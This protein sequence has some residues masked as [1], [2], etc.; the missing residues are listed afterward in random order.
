MGIESIRKNNAEYLQQA[1]I[2]CLSK[3]QSNHHRQLLWLSGE[4]T[5][6]YQQLKSLRLLLT[7]KNCAGVHSKA[8]LNEYFNIEKNQ[9]L[10]GTQIVN[11][12]CYKYLGQEFKT[13]I[14]DAYS[15]LNPDHLAQISPTLMGG[16]VL[17][18][19]TP[20][21]D[22]W[23]NWKEAELNNLFTQPFTRQH[24][25][26]NFLYWIQQQLI[27]DNELLH[28]SQSCIDSNPK[29]T[30]FVSIPSFEN[31]N[32]EHSNE[33]AIIEQAATVDACCTFILDNPNSHMALLAARGRG[34]SAALGLLINRINTYK[35]VVVSASSRSS[36]LQ[37]ERFSRKAINFVEPQLLLSGDFQ[38]QSNTLLLIDESASI[39]VDVLTNLVK[40]FPQIVFST[41]TQGY[42]G[43]GQG[44]KLRFLDYL[45]TK[46]SCFKEF[47]LIHPMRWSAADP[48]ESWLNRSLLLNVDEK[49]VNAKNSDEQIN[50][51]ELSKNSV[52][53]KVKGSELIENPCQLQQLFSLL[54][55]AHYRTTPSDLRIILDSPNVHLWLLMMNRQVIAA[56]LV[57]TEGPIEKFSEDSQGMSGEQLT[58]AM[59]QGLRRPRGNLVPQM[60][61]AQEGLL[62]AK[63]IKIARVV[64]IA[65][66]TQFREQGLASQ[67]LAHIENWAKYKQCDHIAA[68]FSV[69]YDLLQ[70][71]QSQGYSLVRLGNQLDKVTASHN[72]VVLKA[73]TDNES[74]VS[75]LKQSLSIRIRYQRQRIFKDINSYPYIKINEVESS[76]GNVYLQQNMAWCIEQLQVFAEGFRALESAGFCFL[77]LLDEYYDLWNSPRFNETSRELLQH[78]FYENLPIEEICRQDKLH[79]YKGLV[80]TM[81]ET[82]KEFLQLL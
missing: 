44:F 35:Q 68:S 78:Y 30:S 13:I 82:A 28:F 56:C 61:I 76:L 4:Q 75:Q 66:S 12:D 20:D 8:V 77:L 40:K 7:E 79:G 74:L 53:R 54:S 37:I 11:S 15:G 55:Q 23:S 73:L 38:V 27:A 59:Y 1:Y 36:V 81:R 17:I 9:G 25:T 31:K 62:Q 29:Q 63:S 71:W 45:Q 43:T 19:V 41:T 34:K 5:W 18:L 70:F 51:S 72:A 64:R 52:I 46:G 80:R 22:N 21:V 3:A 10:C 2:K 32:I 60:L 14:F 48:V 67:L 57:A 58:I 33:L 26:R 24:V 42:E 50:F 69:Q 16:G 65:T 49:D 39:S 6:C 47:S